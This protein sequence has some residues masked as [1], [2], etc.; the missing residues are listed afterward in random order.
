MRSWLH[1]CSVFHWAL[2]LSFLFSLPAL[3]AVPVVQRFV[4][5]EFPPYSQWHDGQ[6]EGPMEAILQQVCVRMGWRC[7]TTVMP[8]RRALRMMDQHLADGIYVVMDIPARRAA[9]HVSL[10]VLQGRYSLYGREESP[11]RYAGPASLA[12]LQIAAYG[13]SATEYALDQL[14]RGVPAQKLEEL[15]NLTAM[16]KLAR[17]RY[18]RDGLVFIND[19]VAAWLIRQNAYSGLVLKAAIQPIQYCFG[20]SRRWSENEVRRFNAT[21]S[22]LCVSGDTERIAKR[23]GLHAAPCH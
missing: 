11:W 12:G 1:S 10:P 3:A 15:D 6:L 18:G 14:L 5:E 17:R 9:M 22:Q 7:Q 20:L 23:Y 19:D 8:W 2:C 21:L 4:T 13:P 16:S